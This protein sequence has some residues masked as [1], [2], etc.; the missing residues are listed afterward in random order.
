MSS[1][2]FDCLGEK[3]NEKES[4][5]KTNENYEKRPKFSEETHLILMGVREL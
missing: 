2:S 3:D 1:R 4:P 5:Y